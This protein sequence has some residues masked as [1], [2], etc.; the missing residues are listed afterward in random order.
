MSCLTKPLSTVGTVLLQIVKE[1]DVL[2]QTG[3]WLSKDRP[4]FVVCSPAGKYRKIPVIKLVL[5][6]YSHRLSYEPN[7]VT[8]SICCVRIFT[9]QGIERKFL[10]THVETLSDEIHF[11]PPYDIT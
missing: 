3:K 7:V 9:S 1:N 2:R 5:A 8:V 4:W 6:G 10:A 11:L